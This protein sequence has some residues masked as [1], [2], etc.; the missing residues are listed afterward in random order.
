MNE[1]EITGK[2]KISGLSKPRI[3]IDRTTGMLT[4]GDSFS[5]NCDKVDRAAGP[6]F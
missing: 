4:I 1:Q 3:R 2:V 6:R 5:G